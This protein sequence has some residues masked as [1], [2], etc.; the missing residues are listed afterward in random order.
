VDQSLIDEDHSSFDF[1]DAESASRSP[2]AVPIPHL[3]N[4]P[5][6][7]VRPLYQRLLSWPVPKVV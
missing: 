5:Y 6:L 2:V 7:L 4:S 3:L 1:A